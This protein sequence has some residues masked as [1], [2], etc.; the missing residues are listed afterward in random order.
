[1]EWQG[2]PLAGVITWDKF[3]EREELLCLKRRPVTGYDGDAC[4]DILADSDAILQAL[5]A[6]GIGAEGRP[7]HEVGRRFLDILT[8]W[9]NAYKTVRR[10]TAHSDPLKPGAVVAENPEEVLNRAVNK[11]ALAIQDMRRLPDL[12]EGPPGDKRKPPAYRL[13][14]YDH[15]IIAHSREFIQRY[16]SLGRYS[17]LYIEAFN[18][19]VKEAL[20][21]HT[22]CGGG[23]PSQQGFA[24]TCAQ[25][26]RH[27][28]KEQEVFL[29]DYA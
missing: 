11:Y 29:A 7:N 12:I 1:M 3:I 6:L 18:K 20:R 2:S 15:M 9:F 22:T 10:F 14:L 13:K 26:L 25:A 21:Y 24:G 16:G 27:L 5:E 8:R 19:H 4:K 23:R 17:S 28:L